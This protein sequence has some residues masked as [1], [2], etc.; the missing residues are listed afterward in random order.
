PPGAA[1]AMPAPFAFAAATG[2][3]SA[4]WPSVSLAVAVNPDGPACSSSAPVLVERTSS[5]GA[6]VARRQA[7]AP[8]TGRHGSSPNGAAAAVAGKSSAAEMRASGSRSIQR[9]KLTQGMLNTSP[10]LSTRRPT[11]DGRASWEPL[12]LER[13][14]GGPD[15]CR[16]L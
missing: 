6:P 1:A 8:S 3:L 13:F 12:S 2:Q 14:L 4:I 9:R 15:G 10:H 7:A 16:E 5:P 11:H